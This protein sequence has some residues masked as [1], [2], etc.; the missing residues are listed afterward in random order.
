MKK[1][2][3]LLTLLFLTCFFS[4]HLRSQTIDQQ[5]LKEKY[6]E[7]DFWIGNWNVYKYGTDTLVGISKIERI[8]NGTAIQETYES[9]KGKYK[10][11]SLNKFNPKT[12]GWEQFWVDNGGLSLFIQGG[13]QDGKMVLE[14]MEEG[15][16]SKIYNRISW[17]QMDDK[18]IR[19]EWEQSTDGVVWKKVFDGHYRSKSE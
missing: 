19:Q 10:G 8:L 5:T 17:S 12:G 9:A 1:K 6:A 3:Q 14:N 11:T 13:I 16:D 2:I 18:T 7:F 4:P 15:E